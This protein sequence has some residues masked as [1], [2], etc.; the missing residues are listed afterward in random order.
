MLQHCGPCQMY[1]AKK[2]DKCP[3][4]MQSVKVPKE[5]WSQIVEIITEFLH[6]QYSECEFEM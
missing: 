1:N 2:L 4:E 6:W 3:H 5:A